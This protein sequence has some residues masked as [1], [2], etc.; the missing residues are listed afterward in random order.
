MKV[1][2]EYWILIG[3]GVA[4]V[5][6]VFVLVRVWLR[7]RGPKLGKAL[8]DVSIDRLQN[9]LLPDGMGGQIQLEHVLLTAHGLVVDRREGV[10]GHDFRE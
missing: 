7:R 10:R 5:L 8:A 3:A 4:A 9:V 6:A 2:S 1:T